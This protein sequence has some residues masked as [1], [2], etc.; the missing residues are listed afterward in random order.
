MKW[1]TL[2]KWYTTLTQT[3]SHFINNFHW[4]LI[5]WELISWE[6]DLVEVDFMR[7][8][9]VGVDFVGVDFVGMNP[10]VNVLLC[11]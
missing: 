9:F 4:E 6:V 7:V 5:W 3:L 11:R 8:D 2:L 10:T 1:D